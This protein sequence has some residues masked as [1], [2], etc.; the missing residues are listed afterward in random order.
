MNFSELKEKL[1]DRTSRKL[2]AWFLYRN[3][4]SDDVKK[5]AK[6]NVYIASGLGVLIAVAAGAVLFAMSC[7]FSDVTSVDGDDVVYVRIKPGMNSSQIGQLLEKQGVIDSQ[8][9]FWLAVK[10]NNADSRFQAGVF[11]LQRNMKTGDALSVLINGRSVAVRVT[12]PE[13]LNV[14]QV[15][16]LFAEQGLADEKEFLAEARHFAPY[17]YIK[18]V[19]EADYRIEG[20]LFP[21]TYDFAN[22]ATPRDIMQRMADE[23]DRRLTQDMRRQ[24]EERQLSIYELVTLASLV[25]KEARYSEDRPVIAQVF[26]KR[27]AINM[28]L[29]TDTTLQYLREEVK[30]DLSIEDTKMESPYN[31]YLHYGLPPGPIAS[32]GMASIE[33]VLKP[34]DTDYLYFVA[35]RSGHNHYGYTYDEHLGLVEQ[36]R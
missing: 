10:L 9:K 2:E 18:D 13:G 7:A 29:Q 26:F 16:K 20:F 21:D 32:P 35:D 28:P 6:R 24:A 30:E 1:A 8:A 22:D 12:V 36:V 33:A 4:D 15:A 27:L 14:R 19:P 17:D 3:S 5:R 25:E 34:S 11:E 31:T 23:F